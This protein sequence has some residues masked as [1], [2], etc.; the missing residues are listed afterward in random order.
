MINNINR[1][2]QQLSLIVLLCVTT[3]IISPLASKA[4]DANDGIDEFL[5]R[6]YKNWNEHKIEK[7]FENYSTDFVSGDGLGR[8]EFKE[9]TKTLWENYPD[10]S[11]ESQTRTVRT[12]DQYATAS[13]IDFFHGSS[14]KEHPELENKGVLSAISQGQIFLKRFGDSWKIES[15]RTNFELITVHFGDVKKYLDSNQIFFAVPEQARAGSQYTGTIYFILPENIQATATINNELII[16]PPMEVE[17]SFQAVTGHKLERLFTSN[18]SN[19]NELV[20]GTIIVSKGILEPELE[21]LLFISKRVNILPT[22]E[23][24]EDKKIALAPYSKSEDLV[25]LK[26]IKKDNGV[27]ET[28]S[29]NSKEVDN[30]SVEDEDTEN[31]S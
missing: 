17:E 29:K 19:H 25:F 16:S 3:L 24:V 27:N 14:S 11:V 8:K 2:I 6:V 31:E 9:L 22:R 7:L 18:D 1:K 30:G 10:I 12:Q 28:A 26:K 4:I 21:G 13:V 23:E 20:S 5:E 15:D